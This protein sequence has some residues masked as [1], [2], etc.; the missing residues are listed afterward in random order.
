M[1]TPTRPAAD[2]VA[3]CGVKGAW[4]ATLLLVVATA[5]SGGADPPAVRV[6]AAASLRRVFSRIGAEFTSATGRKVEFNFAGSQQL[7]AQLDAGA[8]A[9]VVATADRTTMAK[10]TGL[11]AGSPTVFARNRLT[12]VVG[13]GNPKRIA[14]L[15]DLARPDLVVVLAAP[16]VPAGRYA[17]AALSAAG[18]TVRASSYETDVTAVVGKVA[19][20][21]ADAGICYVTDVRGRDDVAT[22]AIPD[23]ANQIAEYLVG[24]LRDARAPAAEFVALLTGGTGRQLLADAGFS[25]P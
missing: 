11:L 12:I 4:F 15:A 16:A 9:D 18:V 1:R 2:P 13:R 17:A 7:V 25:T 19:L 8:R 24:V 3:S 14:T 6:F 22:V 21:E 20:G 10:L 5:C 23:G